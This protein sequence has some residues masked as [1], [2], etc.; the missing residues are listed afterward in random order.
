MHSLEEALQAAQNEGETEAFVIGGGEIYKQAIGQATRIYLT[1][2]K[3]NLKGDTYFPKIDFSLWCEK[4]REHFS[5]N[6]KNEYAFELIM[7]EKE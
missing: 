2:V 3:T 4:S 5:A 7:L 1:L 6:E